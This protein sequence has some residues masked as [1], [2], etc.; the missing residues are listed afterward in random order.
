MSVKQKVVRLIGIE[1]FWKASPHCIHEIG[2]FI[3]QRIG[4][5]GL[6]K[7]KKKNLLT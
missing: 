6:K 3:D 1:P 5:F 2:V 7:K 4:N